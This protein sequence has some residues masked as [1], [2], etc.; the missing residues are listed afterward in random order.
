MWQ[1]KMK[2]FRYLFFVLALYF[3]SCNVPV[4]P[5]NR[6][7]SCEAV[8]VDVKN[9]DVHV[10]EDS[11]NLSIAL[12]LP[13]LIDSVILSVN[14]TD[15]LIVCNF[16]E[17]IADTLHITRKFSFPEQLRVGFVAYLNNNSRLSDTKTISIVGKK[18]KITVNPKNLYY[19]EPGI[20]CT[21]SVQ[22][23]GTALRYQWFKDGTTLVKDT[24]DTL[25]HSSLT[26]VDNG[27]YKCRVFN[28]WGE[29]ISTP[30]SVLVKVDNS[31]PVYWKFGTYRDSV[32]ERD[33][34][35]VA[36]KS[37]C[38]V[39]NGSVPVFSLLKPSV[40]TYFDDDGNFVFI[41]GKEQ[42]G[43]Y[44]VAVIVYADNNADTSIIS[45][46][47]LPRY[48]QLSCSAEHGTI[49]VKPKQEKYRWGDTVTFTAEPQN[50]YKFYEWNGAFNGITSEIKMIVDND[51]VVT[52]SFIEESAAG[53]H[54]LATGSLT[55]AIK[56]ASPSSQR[57]GSLCPQEGLYDEG[58]IKVWGTVRF[59]FQ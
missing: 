6:Y 4:D 44:S 17:K 54:E 16:E 39:P 11:V 55:T 9:G 22:A 14:D 32:T 56:D 48:Y 29:E 26:D 45:I 38:V 52:A 30:A 42:N 27:E 18:P 21:L 41:A 46:K 10:I 53:C 24:L 12:S 57:P 40:N 5:F 59:I 43:E 35:S 49:T 1:N 51:M 8:F 15:S 50:G 28:N 23:E 31:R 2:I 58:T 19:L 13:H 25:I 20:S 3:L 33:T 34:L 36:M 47:V 37:R 7:D